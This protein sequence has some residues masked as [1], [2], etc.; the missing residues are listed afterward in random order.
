MHLSIFFFLLLSSELDIYPLRDI[1]LCT[2][3]A[4]GRKGT[5]GLSAHANVLF[6]DSV[7]KIFQIPLN[8]KLV[9]VSVNRDILYSVE[10]VIVCFFLFFCSFFKKKKKKKTS[11]KTARG[12]LTKVVL[13]KCGKIPRK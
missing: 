11:N 13:E 6:L 5:A 1:V 9:F 2:T 3:G 10:G 12:N 7:P 4:V 8:R